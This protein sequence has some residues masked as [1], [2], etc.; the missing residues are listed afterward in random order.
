MDPAAKPAR[1]VWPH[2]SIEARRLS[3]AKMAEEP[4]GAACITSSSSVRGLMESADPRE[5]R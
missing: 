4:A 1:E 2:V 3:I 5:G